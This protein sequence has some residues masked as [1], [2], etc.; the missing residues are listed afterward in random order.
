MRSARR[1]LATEVHDRAGFRWAP[2]SPSV[3]DSSNLRPVDSQMTPQQAAESLLDTFK[4]AVQQE[5]ELL[6][7]EC[8]E[9]R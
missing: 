7:E 8:E 9:N 3:W 1:L 6:E 5:L 4:L 2:S